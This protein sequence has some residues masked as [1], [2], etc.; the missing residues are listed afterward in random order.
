MLATVETVAGH[1]ATRTRAALAAAQRLSFEA[2]SPETKSDIAGGRKLDGRPLY[3]Y[4]VIPGGVESAE[5]LKDAVLHDPVVAAHYA[6]FH[7]AQA[8]VIRLDADRAMYVSYR[9]GDR[10][11]WT[12][13]TLTI[14]KGETLISDGEHE[15][16]TRCGNRLSEMPA[17]PVSPEQPAKE[18]LAAPEAPILFTGNFPPSPGLPLSPPSAEPPTSPSTPPG[19]II[20]P[21]VF[22]IVGGGPPGSQPKSPPP[23]PPPPVAV[24]EPG[25]LAL[26]A[27]GLVTLLA[28][29]ALRAIREKRKA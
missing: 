3:P 11:F 16:R 23:P 8:R 7:L 19:G 9:L 22:P 21:P 15:A 10:V 20:P 4:S 29:G 26:L 12:N 25:T 5:E 18:V 24:P 17:A 27:T 28:A 13:R 6:D 14:H 1:R 2:P